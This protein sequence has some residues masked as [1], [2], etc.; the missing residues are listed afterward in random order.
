MLSQNNFENLF[1]DS[2]GYPVVLSYDSQV[3]EFPMHW[4]NYA[5]IMYL[6]KGQISLEVAGA[7]YHM[8]E[9]E[10]LFIW[11]GELHAIL[12]N[13][14]PRTTVLQFDAGLITQIP[15][16]KKSYHSLPKAR[17]ISEAANPAVFHEL[18]KCIMEIHQYRLQEKLDAKDILIPR[19]FWDVNMCISI[20]RFLIHTFEYE[21]QILDERNSIDSHVPERTLQCVISTCSYISSNCTDDLTLEDV[22]AHAGFSKYHFSRLFKSYT[23]SSFTEYLSGCRIN[24]AKSLLANPEISIA[25]IA[26]QAGFGSI[27]SFNRV[28]RKSEGCTPSEFRTFLEFLGSPGRS[29]LPEPE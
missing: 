14:R 12:P 7:L 2:D 18:T 4:H 25:D 20:Y 17:L 29:T 6:M 26:M 19:T 3:A 28:F 24:Y 27:A 11:P 16:L 10:I 1:H 5:E 22:A 13:N 8:N 9:N 21:F 23:G 15:S